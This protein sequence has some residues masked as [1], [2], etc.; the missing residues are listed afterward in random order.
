MNEIFYLVVALLVVIAVS[1]KK[2]KVALNKAVDLYISNARLI[3][4]RANQTYQ[5]AFQSLQEMEKS[6]KM[7]DKI[8]KEKFIKHSDILDTMLLDSNQKIQ[9]ELRRQS[10]AIELWRKT[11]EEA[12]KRKVTSEFLS[13]KI[14]KVLDNFRNQDGSANIDQSLI[15][16]FETDKKS[17]K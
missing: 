17:I 1:Y 4:E 5:D 16:A 9:E 6:L 13:K 12:I 2:I 14:D 7:Q 8:N 11:E 3:I 15:K 10:N